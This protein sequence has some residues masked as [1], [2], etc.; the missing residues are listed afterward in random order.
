MIPIIFNL[1]VKPSVN[2]NTPRLIVNGSKPTRAE[3]KKNC[4]TTPSGNRKLINSPNAVPMT[5]PRN[6][7][8]KIWL[9]DLCFIILYSMNVIVIMLTKYKKKSD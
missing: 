6:K 5:A 9:N 4:S 1:N 3:R 2:V 8:K 7:I